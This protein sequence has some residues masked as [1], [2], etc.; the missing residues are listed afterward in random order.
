[1]ALDGPSGSGKTYTGL[2]FATALAKGVGNGRV[3]VIDT[4]RG[5][6]AKYADRFDFDVLALETFAPKLYCE[7][8]EAAEQANYPVIL[9][10]SLTHAWEGEGG[11]LDLHDQAT[12]R[13]STQNSFTAWKDVTPVHRRLVDAI[14]TSSAHIIVTMRS[15]MEYIQTTENGRSVIKKVGMAP[16][17]RQGI[18]YEFDIVGDLDT[19]HNLAITKSRCFAITDAVVN[20]P[21]ADWFKAVKDWLSDGVP[22]AKPE[23]KKT[24][25]PAPAPK[26]PTAEEQPAPLNDWI[27]NKDTRMAF[28]AQAKDIGYTELTVHQTLHVTSMRFYKGSYGD[29]I[30]AL[31]EAKKPLAPF[32][33]EDVEQEAML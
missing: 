25:P 21:T 10:D 17:Q 3:A 11:V 4:E 27:A 32:T 6:A 20:K 15:K 24:V 30:D 13:Q 12:R 14:L 8:I 31:M 18:E 2:T 33:G 22:M 5:S 1:M 28:W 29:A 19:D 7:A 9:I 26:A 16:V 23:P